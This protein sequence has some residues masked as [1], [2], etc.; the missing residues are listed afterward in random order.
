[1][2]F[3][4]ETQTVAYESRALSIE[5]SIK[6]PYHVSRFLISCISN[7]MPPIVIL[8]PE[9]RAARGSPPTYAAKLGRLP[10]DALSISGSCPK[11]RSEIE[12][13]P[14]PHHHFGSASR[15]PCP[16]ERKSPTQARISLCK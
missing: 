12:F 9:D 8:G 11:A 4:K 6:M 7:L 15:G 3:F 14:R 5:E 2:V 1:M 16:D 13:C 10:E